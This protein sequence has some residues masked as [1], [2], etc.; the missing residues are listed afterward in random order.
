M[1]PARILMIVIVL[2]GLNPFG[3]YFFFILLY[4]FFNGLSFIKKPASHPIRWLALFTSLLLILVKGVFH[5]WEDRL[6]E[7]KVM[8]MFV[9]MIKV[10]VHPCWEVLPVRIRWKPLIF[11][12]KNNVFYQVMLLVI[13]VGFEVRILLFL[14]VN[15]FLRTK[16]I[17]LPEIIFTDISI[18]RF[19]WWHVHWDPWGAQSFAFA[20]H[21]APKR[22]TEFLRQWFKQTD[23]RCILA[24]LV[25]LLWHLELEAVL[26]VL[27][28]SE[29]I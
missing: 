22:T 25:A 16:Y 19:R 8:E 7:L 27:L 12:V 1:I 10:P 13:G 23:F 26:L 15:I 6:L 5:Y 28:D 9:P 3:F 4:H 11:L 2:G 18:V 17:L 29:D 24:F 21:V 14:Y 20:E